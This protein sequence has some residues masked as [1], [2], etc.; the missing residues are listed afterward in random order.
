M[1]AA[2]HMDA[3]DTTIRESMHM[4][5]IMPQTATFFSG[6]LQGEALASAYASADLFVLPSET[7]TLGLVL[8]EAMACGLPTIAS[9]ATAGPDVLTDSCGRLLP[10]GDLD[11]LVDALR[12]FG[13][14]RDRLPA[15]GRAAR[16]RARQCTWERYRRAVIEA[17]AS[18]V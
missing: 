16:E 12:W 18:L 13:Q 15:M 8:L 4:S 6:Y 17:T 10:T 7:E 11:A 14:N 9:E 5:N 2:N 3:T 1:V